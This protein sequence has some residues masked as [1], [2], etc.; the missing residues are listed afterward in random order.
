MLC[1]NPDAKDKLRA[2]AW[3]LMLCGHTHGGQLRLPGIGRPFAPVRDVRYVEGL[4]PWEGR[5]IHITRGIGNL[6]GLR[7]NCRPEI[8]LLNLAGYPR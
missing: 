5:L 7:F 2:S 3:D 4:R 1:H 6:H 8:N